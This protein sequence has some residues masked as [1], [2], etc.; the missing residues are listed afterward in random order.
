M[1]SPVRGAESPDSV[2][3]R[4]GHG[5]SEPRTRVTRAGY[6]PGMGPTSGA[7]QSMDTRAGN[8]GSPVVA[9]G[10]ERAG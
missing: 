6:P 10:T 1:V 3:G 7:L 4:Q 8:L 5:A 9:A 2:D